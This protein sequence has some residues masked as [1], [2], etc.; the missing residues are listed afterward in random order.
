[1]RPMGRI[2]S[3]CIHF[4]LYQGYP[5]VHGRRECAPPFMHRN[6]PA[7]NNCA[8]REKQNMK[9][10]IMAIAMAMVTA[11]ATAT[12]L[13]DGLVGYWPFDGDAKDYSGNG[14]HGT[15]YGVTLTADRSGKAGCAY[16]FDG[17]SYVEVPGSSSLQ[18]SSSITLAAWVKPTEYGHNTIDT[19]AFVTI[20]QGNGYSFQFGI[21]SGVPLSRALVYGLGSDAISD[22]QMPGLNAWH[23]V[24]LS[25][26]A[27]IMKYY[28]NG[29]LVA[30]KNVGGTVSPSSGNLLIGVHPSGDYEYHIG[31][32]E[33]VAIW[34]RQLSSSE[35]ASFYNS[36]LKACKVSFNPNDG[37]GSMDEANTLSGKSLTLPANQFTRSGYVFLGWALAPDGEVVY[38]DGE[39]IEVNS[40]MTLYAVWERN[41]QDFVVRLHG[42]GGE[43]GGGDLILDVNFYLDESNAL[44]VNPFMCDRSK[45]LGWS[46][47]TD[48]FDWSIGSGLSELIS[49]GGSITVTEDNLLYWAA[50]DGAE[51]IDGIPTL[52]LYAIWE[53]EV[54]TTFFNSGKPSSNASLA[55]PDLANHLRF[56]FG[57]ESSGVWHLSGETVKL[58]PGKH[59]ISCRVD[60]GYEWYPR[61]WQLLDSLGAPIGTSAGGAAADFVIESA[62]SIVVPSDRTAALSLFVQV[63]AA[64]EKVGFVMFQCAD[65]MTAAQ[66]AAWP[67]FPTFD[68]SKVKITLRPSSGGGAGLVMRIGEW[69]EL[70]VGEYLWNAEYADKA[71]SMEI[72][73]WETS[74]YRSITVEEGR[75][76][77]VEIPFLPFGREGAHSFAK[78]SFDGNGSNVQLG[79]MWFVAGSQTFSQFSV[80][81]FS[82]NRIPVSTRPG[83]LYSYD[84]L[85]N[86]AGGQQKIRID[87]L[88]AL[89]N[90]VVRWLNNNPPTR[91]FSFVADWEKQ[92]TWLREKASKAMTANSGNYEA[93][94]AMPAANG[95]RTVGEC[96][97]LGIDPEDPDDDF[98]IANF[99]MKDGKPVITLNH[100]ED[101]SGNSF[102][103]RI[104]TLGAKELGAAAQWD[105][106]TDLQDYG[107]EQGYRF[108]KVDVELP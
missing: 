84:W 5:K 72:P 54:T 78:L 34:N 103:T 70:P 107:A 49:D 51:V 90:F 2:F 32:M 19:S 94:A 7:A 23:F 20:L 26:N 42:N 105:D 98:R 18:I 16:N 93:V 53:T 21:V 44:P 8:E 35:I 102:A 27:G 37:T 61:T 43:T 14:N 106:V 31:A 55:P 45:F 77:P 86:T 101:G 97:A 96:Y 36:G 92:E 71:G 64:E 89:R 38:R 3:S 76:L 82:E 41:A 52:H 33:E 91:R 85:C 74:D 50:H 68:V 59:Q 79:E 88:Q 87:S 100:T 69:E 11:I 58:P 48:N 104:R 28:K 67:D 46:V 40:N 80:D 62:H 99:E 60:S 4:S 65:A 13:T 30:S 73:Y 9:K 95:C 10:L 75:S 15:T 56:R 66:K 81:K 1:M 6:S 17:A 63:L 12:N 29:S 108:F 24:A 57:Y 25:F 47:G 22:I 39:E 83:D